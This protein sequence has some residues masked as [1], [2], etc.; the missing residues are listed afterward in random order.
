MIIKKP[1]LIYVKWMD[2]EGMAGWNDADKCEAWI[3]EGTLICESVGWKIWEDDSL[4]VL[5]T[6]TNKH[7]W[8]DCLKLPKEVVIKVKRIK[9]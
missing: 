8:G 7:H 5:A 1:Y 4:L 6:S 2:P 9:I 3:K